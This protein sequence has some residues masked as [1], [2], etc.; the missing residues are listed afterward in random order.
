MKLIASFLII[1]FGA[2]GLLA[3]SDLQKLVDTEH[4]FAQKAEESG[5]KAAFLA[6]MTDD[7]LVFNPDAV[8]GKAY[9]NA[10]GESKGLLSWAPN[11]ADISGNGIL[12]YTTG[13]WEYRPKGE[14]DTPSAFGDFITLWLRQPDGRYKFVVD[15]GVGH[16]KP[17]RYSTDWTTAM[18]GKSG[19]KTSSKP[20]NDAEGEFYQLAA[21]KRVAKAYENFADKNIRSYREDKLP[22]LGKKNVIKLLKTDKAEYS[23]AKR[24]S[25]F[26]SD[27]IS[28]NLNTYTKTQDGKVVEKGNFLLIWK[29]YGGKWH[30]VL[31]IFKPV[32]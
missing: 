24:S 21:A 20:T 14:E 29:F 17:E 26:R 2:A 7:A 19:Q 23:F 3:Q 25:S 30:I 1:V 4:A 12:G 27:N 31:D 5:T 18:P 9:W 8:N 6:N 28:Y 16:P 32:R 15:I 10:R 13:N 11:Y 22:F